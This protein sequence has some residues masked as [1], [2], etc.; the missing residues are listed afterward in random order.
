MTGAPLPGPTAAQWNRR[1][2][3]VLAA[4][5]GVLCLD[6]ILIAVRIPSHPAIFWVLGVAGLAGFV[7]W[8]VLGGRAQRRMRDEL[9]AGYSTVIDAAGYDLRNAD[10]GAI[11]RDRSVAPAPDRPRRRSFVLDNFRLRSGT[12]LERKR[13]DDEE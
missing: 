12:W 5:I 11:E 6:L 1:A 2:L 10:T 4:G 8:I 3:M 9:A 13:D 7:G